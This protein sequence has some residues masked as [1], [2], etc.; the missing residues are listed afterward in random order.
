MS[1]NRKKHKPNKRRLTVVEKERMIK[2]RRYDERLEGES[3]AYFAFHNLISGGLFLFITTAS[4]IWS[5]RRTSILS[6]FTSE[7]VELIFY[8][9][10][11]YLATGL[12][13]RFSAFF[14]MKYALKYDGKIMKKFKELNKGMNRLGVVWVLSIFISS[15]IFSLGIIVLL[16]DA[17]YGKDTVFTLIGTYCMIRFFIWLGFKI[18]SYFKF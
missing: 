4:G 6:I 17:I 7:F 2:H 14:I 10:I 1:Q 11:I 12:F 15:V 16:Q 13:G 8:L 5:M 3:L 18:I 9:F